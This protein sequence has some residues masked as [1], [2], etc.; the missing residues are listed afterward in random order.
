M[1]RVRPWEKKTG[2][3]FSNVKQKVKHSACAAPM[4]RRH[5]FKG[6]PLQWSSVIFESR[7]NA[8]KKFGSLKRGG[9]EGKLIL[10]NHWTYIWK[11]ESCFFLPWTDS[12]YSQ[13]P[14]P[15]TS[16]GKKYILALNMCLQART[17]KGSLL[18]GCSAKCIHFWIFWCALISPM[19]GICVST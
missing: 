13:Y 14:M 3:S 16:Y 17:S 1:N 7:A 8:N 6:A 2:L 11:P 12:V 19:G 15:A 9:S 10:R 5:P 4:I 18:I